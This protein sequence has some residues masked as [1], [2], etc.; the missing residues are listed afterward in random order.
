LVGP[1]D[2][3]VVIEPT[4]SIFHN[5]VLMAGTEQRGVPLELSDRC[6]HLDVDRVRAAIDR[7]TRILIINSPSNPT[8]WVASPDD[9]RAL[10][11]LAEEH[12]LTILADEVYERIVFDSTLAPSFARVVQNRKRLV[13][14]NS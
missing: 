8:G 12:D 5:A 14:V 6:F 1:G 7:N 2:N 11:A 4:Y 9:Q 3:A 13:V 10:Y